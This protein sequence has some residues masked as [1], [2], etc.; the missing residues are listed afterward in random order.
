M[1]K[2]VPPSAAQLAQVKFLL[3]E[4]GEPVSETLW[5]LSLGKDRFKLSNI[6]VYVFGVSVADIVLAR[7]DRIHRVP[8]FQR[9]IMKSGNRTVRALFATTLR[10]EQAVPVLE[11]MGCGME[12]AGLDILAINVPPRTNLPDVLHYLV[13]VEAEWE[14]ADSGIHAS[15]CAPLRA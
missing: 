14:L 10:R 6:P 5:A 1:V 2:S 15:T 7:Y 4:G 3:E 8:V 11:R 12:G 13:Q 9:I